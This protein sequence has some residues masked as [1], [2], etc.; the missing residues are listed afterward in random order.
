MLRPWSPCGMEGPSRD[1][2]VRVLIAST[3]PRYSTWSNS[4][5]C[6]DYKARSEG[7]ES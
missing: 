4:P 3:A 7:L 5:V 1:V 6:V 2:G